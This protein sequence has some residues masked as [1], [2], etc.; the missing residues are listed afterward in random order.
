MVAGA[1]RRQEAFRGLRPLNPTRDLK[2]VVDLLRIAFPEELGRPEAAWL[3]DVE[4]LGALKPLIWLANQFN[5]ALGGFFYGFVWI[6]EGRVVG[7]VTIS[8]LTPQN[9]L[10]S[11]VAVHPD[12]RRRGIARDLMDAS[13]DWIAGR[14]ARWVTLEVRRENVPAK[15]LYFDMGFLLVEGTTELERHGAEQTSRIAPPDGY[16]LRPARLDD[17]PQ[18]FELARRVTPALAQRIEP[19]R[20]EEYRV[21]RLD[22]VAEGVRQFLGLPATLRWVATDA[23]GHLVALLKVQVGGYRQ[24]LHLL[25]HPDLHG[26]LEEALVTRGLDALAGRRGVIRAQIDADHTEAIVALEAQG[27]REI[28]TLDRMALELVSDQ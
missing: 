3:R 2:Q 6:E 27:F 5:M 17:A 13:V 28:R 15:S 23:G 25:I 11:N 26:A 24:Q 12:F 20:Q 7:N 19:I 22:R 9:W 21:G 14:N 16:R 18:M 10:I 8:R 1:V 4:I